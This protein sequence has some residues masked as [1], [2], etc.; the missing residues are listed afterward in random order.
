MKGKKMGYARK[1]DLCGDIHYHED[2]YFCSANCERK[3]RE[4]GGK[5]PQISTLQKL[6][7]KKRKR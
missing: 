7:D 3:Y 6:W 2:T 5:S 4:K 1:C